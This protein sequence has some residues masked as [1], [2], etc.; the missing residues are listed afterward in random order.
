MKFKK[1]ALKAFIDSFDI[2]W[3]HQSIV[4]FL[5]GETYNVSFPVNENIVAV[6]E[7]DEYETTT[8]KE[9]IVEEK[10]EEVQN[11]F[12]STI[13]VV[14]DKFPKTIRE[15]V[16]ILLK[17]Y[18]TNLIPT[19]L[20]EIIGQDNRI[21]QLFTNTKEDRWV[22]HLLNEFFCCVTN[23]NAAQQIHMYLYEDCK[24]IIQ[25]RWK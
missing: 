21:V 5:N 17:Q 11:I 4:V 13:Q 2:I 25:N 15:E 8:E 20:I 22:I 12:K 24:N 6:Y 3:C 14:F 1:Y 7:W 18:G 19:D 23:F 9:R 10:C 16:Y